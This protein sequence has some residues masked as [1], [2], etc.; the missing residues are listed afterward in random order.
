VLTRQV[1]GALSLLNESTENGLTKISEV[2]EKEPGAEVEEG[3][4]EALTELQ[5]I[6]R[7]MQRL[8]NVKSCM[9]D[10]S[11]AVGDQG[12]AEITWKDAVADRYV[13][14][15]ERRVLRDEL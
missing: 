4:M 15:E 11:Q 10:W 13:M 14:E 1:E 2:L 5:N 12:Q 6:D 8:N 7:V 3:I 9:E